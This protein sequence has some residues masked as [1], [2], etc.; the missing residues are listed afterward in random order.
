M[1]EAILREDVR[2]D[3]EPGDDAATQ[4]IVK[5]G[6]L[7]RALTADEKRHMSQL[8][9]ALTAAIHVLSDFDTPP[10]EIPGAVQA[11]LD[12]LA[13]QM[14]GKIVAAEDTRQEMRLSA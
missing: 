1:A 6:D 4:P 3:M 2:D 10:K 13:R 8:F 9:P 11:E 5:D 14:H 7:V 12:A